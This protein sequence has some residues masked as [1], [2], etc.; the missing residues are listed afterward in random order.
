MCL[1]GGFVLYITV[2]YYGPAARMGKGRGKEGAGLYPDLAVF[3]ISEGSSPALISWVGRQC[4]LLPSYEIARRE[5]AAQGTALDI[6]VVHRI[7]V[8]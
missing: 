3:G 2:L 6:N 5:L 4:A 1:L 8:N 7:A